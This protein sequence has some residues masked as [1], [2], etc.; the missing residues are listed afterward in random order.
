MTDS[1]LYGNNYAVAEMLANLT[2]GVF[3]E[4]LNSEV[5]TTRQNVQHIYVDGLLAALSELK[6]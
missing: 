5:T 1:R 3:K 4:D 2:D 6:V